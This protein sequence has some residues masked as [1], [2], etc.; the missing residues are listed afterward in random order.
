ML[1]GIAIL[2]LLCL[3]T[4]AVTGWAHTRLRL[5]R[6]ITEHNKLKASLRKPGKHEARPGEKVG[7]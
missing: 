2:S 5:S 3:L 1:T 7:I 6:K 4:I